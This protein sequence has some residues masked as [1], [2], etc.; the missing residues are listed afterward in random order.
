M[1]R[2]P[3]PRTAAAP[4]QGAHRSRLPLPRRTPALTAPQRDQPP[5]LAALFVY[6]RGAAAERCTLGRVVFSGAAAIGRWGGAGREEL[7]LPAGPTRGRRGAARRLVLAPGEGELHF[8]EGSGGRPISPRVRWFPPS[9][10]QRRAPSS[11]PA[12]V[13][14][15][16]SRRGGRS[17]AGLRG[18]LPPPVLPRRPSS[19]RAAAGSDSPTGSLSPEP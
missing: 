10:P 3:R 19:V 5:S 9:L 4:A 7:Q 11:G 18:L 14:L 16:P 2:Q 8:P 17:Q 13:F 6:N 12:V 1:C 15:S